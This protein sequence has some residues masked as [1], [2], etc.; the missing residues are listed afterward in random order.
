MRGGADLVICATGWRQG[1]SILSEEMR[2]AVKQGEHFQL[3]R[4]ILPPTE[5]RLGF[6]G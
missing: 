2:A 6:V 4:R 3:Y 1:V 5:R